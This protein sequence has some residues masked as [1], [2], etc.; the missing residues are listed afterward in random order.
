MVH[1]S[2][3]QELC[4]GGADC[5]AFQQDVLSFRLGKDALRKQAATLESVC[6]VVVRKVPEKIG[7]KR[8]EFG[9]I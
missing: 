9:S 7:K 8:G 5:A 4:N 2:N 3:Q 1:A 6:G